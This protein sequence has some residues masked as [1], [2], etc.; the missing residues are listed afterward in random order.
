[1][2]LFAESGDAVAIEAPTNRLGREIAFD[3]A[4]RYLFG[5]LDQDV[6]GI[7]VRL[8]YTLTPNLTLQY[9]GAPFLSNGSYKAH[10]RIT[11]PRA[12]RYADRF[13]VYDDDQL[14]ATDDGYD[15]DENDDG[16]A[17]A[18]ARVGEG[19][20]RDEVEQ[21]GQKLRLGLA[22]VGIS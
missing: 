9:Y 19:H 7:T 6:V 3:V 17:D 11:D 1:M 5:S 14:T 18:T 13:A 16:A 12:D 20:Q 4:A 2:R 10:K 21:G 22:Q 15:V 8:E